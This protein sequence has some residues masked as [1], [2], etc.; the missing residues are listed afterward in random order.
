[1]SM[2]AFLWT[3]APSCSYIF[4]HP[5]L[6]GRCWEAFEKILGRP[7]NQ[8]TQEGFFRIGLF[9]LFSLMFFVTFNDLRDLGLF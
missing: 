2:R 5:N 6:L 7:L 1:M 9:L 8:K 4:V 3:R